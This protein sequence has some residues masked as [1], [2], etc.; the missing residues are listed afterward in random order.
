MSDE[1]NNEE[2]EFFFQEF[3]NIIKY[4]FLLYFQEYFKFVDVILFNGFFEGLKIDVI[5]GKDYNV[6]V[7]IILLFFFMEEDKFSRF[8]LCDVYCFEVKVSIILD[9]KDSILVVLSEKVSLLKS[10]FLSLFLLLFL[11]KIFLGE[12]SVNFF[13]M[14]NEIKVFVEVEVVLVFFEVI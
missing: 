14:F 4:E 13:L 9:I 1:I 10:L 6:L 11:E 8:V 12:C 7:F 3:V 5:D 2:M